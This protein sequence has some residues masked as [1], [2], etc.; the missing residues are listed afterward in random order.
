MTTHPSCTGRPLST[1][2]GACSWHPR[3]LIVYINGSQHAQE[4]LGLRVDPGAPLVGC[5]TRL[6]PQKGCH[7]IRHALFATRDAGGQVC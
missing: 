3:G 5:I 6:V 7:L 4:G 2:Q 1:S